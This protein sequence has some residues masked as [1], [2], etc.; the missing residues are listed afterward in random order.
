MSV[1]VTPGTRGIPSLFQFLLVFASIA[2]AA[3]TA[4]GPPSGR[5]AASTTKTT[6]KLIV[7]PRVVERTTTKTTRDR[8]RV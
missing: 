7:L 5:K 3:R 1:V 6:P 2:F 8:T 4:I